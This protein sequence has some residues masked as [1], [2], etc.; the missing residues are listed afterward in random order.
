MDTTNQM[1]DAEID[2]YLDVCFFY[3]NFIFLKM[4]D[5]GIEV[6]IVHIDLDNLNE[7]INIVVMI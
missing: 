6:N 2:T 7:R 4:K 1:D 5:D 3:L